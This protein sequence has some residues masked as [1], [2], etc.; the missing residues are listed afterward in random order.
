MLEIDHI[1]LH[2]DS[3]KDLKSFK[4][5]LD[6]AGI[7]FE[8]T[9]GKK[10]KGFQISNIWFGKQYLEV[11]NITEA[12]NL[13]QPK[14]AKRHSVGERGAYCIFFKL[15]TPISVLNQTLQNSGIIVTQPERTEFKWFAGLLTKKL[16]WQFC[17]TSKIPG[18]NIEVGFI[19]YDDG[20][21]QKF[22]PYMVPNSTDIGLTGLTKPTVYS[23][24]PNEARHWLEKL[25]AII[26]CTVNLSI[27]ERI[28]QVALQ[29][30]V[31][32]SNEYNFSGVE[33]SDV[34]LNPAGN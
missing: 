8:P 10:A 23:N 34:S 12:E 7:P 30:I 28:N 3:A 18:T 15:T 33:L 21:E 32:T 9:W 27:E 31:T 11:V 26:G 20:A 19:E 14:W 25:Q 24:E 1:V 6:E 16:P 4:A 29:L 22:A 17:L 5:K 13:W 2:A